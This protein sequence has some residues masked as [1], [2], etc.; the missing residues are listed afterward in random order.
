ME[1]IAC[2][3][4]SDPE[5]GCDKGHW[6]RES[7]CRSGIRPATLVLLEI[8]ERTRLRMVIS[9]C[10]HAQR[11]KLFLIEDMDAVTR[12]PHVRTECPRLQRRGGDASIES[13]GPIIARWR[14]ASGLCIKRQKQ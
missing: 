13:R 9:G 3:P 14:I 11:A 12:R 1:S 5:P 4:V 10:C 6:R 8:I 7:M 2:D